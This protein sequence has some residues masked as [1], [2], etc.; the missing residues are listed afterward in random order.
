M[1][2]TEASPRRSRRAD[3]QARGGACGAGAAPQ[4]RGTSNDRRRRGELGDVLRR[5][6]P[7]RSPSARSSHVGVDAAHRKQHR[8][9]APARPA[10]AY[11]RLDQRAVRGPSRRP[12]S[13]SK[14][15]A[16][17]AGSAARDSQRSKLVRER[18]ARAPTASRRA[19]KR[20][21]PRALG[22]AP[23]SR[24]R[25]SA[26]TTSS[27]APNAGGERRATSSSAIHRSRSTARARGRAPLA[28]PVREAAARSAGTGRSSR[29]SAGSRR[30]SRS[31]T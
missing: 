12:S 3:A 26:V 1:S 31:V 17:A 28:S 19:E 20:L 11:Q 29:S 5:A 24:L 15:A 7:P 22:S 4:P 21:A 9:R 18:R 30:G 2:S 8:R 23:S 14:F 16:A 10:D 27:G 6:T 13:A 25:W